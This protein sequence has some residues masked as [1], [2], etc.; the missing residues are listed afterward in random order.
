MGN[1]VPK[2]EHGHIY[3]QSDKPFYYSGD[4]VNGTIY[5][6]LFRNFPGSKINLKIK[7]KE[8]TH[9]EEDRVHQERDSNGNLHSRTE[10]IHHHGKNDF[11]RH[12]I[13][14]YIS[15]AHE[16]TAGQYAFPFS[17]SLG[18]FLPGSFFDQE[19]RLKAIIKVSYFI[20]LFLPQICHFNLVQD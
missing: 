20:K 17:F 18:A 16:I 7:G 6:D 15:H 12:K 13:P 14:I 4:Q 8:E 2:F 1:H 10:I 5:L 3:I 11:Y 9:W 19:T